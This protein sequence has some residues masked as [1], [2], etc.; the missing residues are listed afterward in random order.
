M[1]KC[2]KSYKK[3]DKAKERQLKGQLLITKSTKTDRLAA[4]KNFKPCKKDVNSLT[5]GKVNYATKE[6]QKL[7]GELCKSYPS[8]LKSCQMMCGL[9]KELYPEPMKKSVCAALPTEWYLECVN[10][11][12]PAPEIISLIEPSK[13]EVTP[14]VALKEP[15]DLNLEDLT[16]L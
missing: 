4:C 6:G 1:I 13:P 15:E 7:N 9:F 8:N 12:P 2:R 10:R 14:P 3:Y 16:K 11:L 5:V